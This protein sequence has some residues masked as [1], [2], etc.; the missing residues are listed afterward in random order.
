M[1]HSKFGQF[2]LRRGEPLQQV[3]DVSALPLAV[4]LLWRYSNGK[5][6]GRLKTWG[7]A[8]IFFFVQLGSCV[9]K[10]KNISYKI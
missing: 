3:C 5:A 6:M 1:R 4:H 8:R 10:K 7:T 9:S 2:E